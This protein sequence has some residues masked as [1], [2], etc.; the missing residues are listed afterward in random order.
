MTTE[1]TE[2]HRLQ[3]AA[4]RSIGAAIENLKISIG[5]KLVA[6]MASMI[7]ILVAMSAVLYG[8]LRSVAANYEGILSSRTE[9]SASSAARIQVEFKLQVQDWKDVL[10]R[11]FDPKDLNNYLGQ[12]RQ[13]IVLVQQ[14]SDEVFRTT[15]DDVV[16]A[17]LT[18]F[19]ADH[20]KLNRDYEAALVPF[21]A[22]GAVDPRVP[23][24]AVRGRDRPLDAELTKIVQRIETTIADRA[25]A[26]NSRV[27]G[28]QQVLLIVASVALLLVIMVFLFTIRGI[29]LP[30]RNLTRAAYRAAYETLPG[31]IGAVR[32]LEADAEPPE[33]PSIEVHTRDE[34]RELGDALTTMQ[35]RAVSLAVEQHRYERA[36]SA[37]LIDLGRRNQSLLKR[38]LGYITVLESQERDPDVLAALFRID[39]VTTRVRRNA[40][41][42]LVLAG[43][44]QSSAGTRPA[45]VV[46]V[47][48]AALS[49]IEEYVRVDPYMVEHA[50]VAGIGV[51]D[52]VH[53]LAEL[54]ENAT[55]FSP[56]STQVAVVG[57]QMG[58]RY[59]LRVVDRGVGM[60]SAEM[61][62]ANDR[63]QRA[64]ELR[65]YTN[66]LGLHVVGRLA[67]RHGIEVLL[68]QSAGRGVTATVI[69]PRT[70]VVSAGI[71]IVDELPTVAT[72]LPVQPLPAQPLPVQPLPVRAAPRQAPQQV[73]QR[74]AQQP[75]QQAPRVVDADPE[76]V[77]DTVIPR[78]VRGAQLPDT[79]DVGW[80]EAAQAAPEP[81]HV[82]SQLTALAAGVE[83]ARAQNRNARDADLLDD[84]QEGA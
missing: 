39:H 32:Q 45:A 42:M 74:V 60:T 17:E 80:S 75:P 21:I 82:R 81:A 43:A 69:L 40:E 3:V 2:G 19:R 66:V 84:E 11:G 25:A 4:P 70:M 33:P 56:P 64:A 28:R 8:D 79:D 63:I 77:D 46:D 35:S 54:M 58:D 47:I 29:V 27:A 78:R 51:S 30:I 31:T 83:S 34:L 52:L 41:S 13:Q 76:P 73:P 53:L 61:Q 12:F 1:R 67:A 59:R 72:P 23:D 15:D 50:F 57:Q 14:A 24:R 22:G 7:V 44:R 9:N 65:T 10:L 71:E 5:T 6:I 16:R 55:R 36:T 26:E 48:R 20:D 38:T 68:E 62:E 49:E 37:M 18:A